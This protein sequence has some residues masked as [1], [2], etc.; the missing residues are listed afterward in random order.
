MQVMVTAS[1]VSSTARCGTGS[2]EKIA[3]YVGSPSP[4][5]YSA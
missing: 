2:I 4:A 1:G 3:M 5:T